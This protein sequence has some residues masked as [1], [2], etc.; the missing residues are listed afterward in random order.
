MDSV[1]AE[2]N[3]RLRIGR[4]GRTKKKMWVNDRMSLMNMVMMIMMMEYL[5]FILCFELRCGVGISVNHL[6][7]RKY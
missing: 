3:F 6:T 4:R 2:G 5:Y 7:K 1:I